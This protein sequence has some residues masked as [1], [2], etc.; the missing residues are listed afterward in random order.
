MHGSSVLP[1]ADVNKFCIELRLLFIG[2]LAAILP[3]GLMLYFYPT[4]TELFW[5]WVMPNS[6]S[7]TLLGAG[8]VGLV[9]YA[10]IALVE[11]RWIQVRG[12]LGA[13]SAFSLVLMFATIL[14]WD[15]FRPYHP[16]TIIWLTLYYSAPFLVPIIS[17]LQATRGEPEDPRGVEL[18]QAWHGWL[19]VRSLIYMA[20]AL[21]VLI[22]AEWI[23]G[24]WPWPIQPLELR[25]FMG[26]FV[27]IG[28]G[29]V[30]ALRGGNRYLWHYRVGLTVSAAMGL[31]QLLGFVV[32]PTPYDWST[33]F[34]IILPLIFAEWVITPLLI[35][36]LYGRKRK[37]GI[38]D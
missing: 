14:H 28:W 1:R 22:F 36:L 4:G 32:N 25:V 19:L 29:A 9:S 26:Q 20:I 3:L 30:I 12:G 2:I 27:V 6:R 31:L 34:G 11:N 24:Q 33:P 23:A 18:S 10:L 15:S 37:V 8:Y 38:G 16:V 7:A 13:V 17:R 35:M 21:F 5:A